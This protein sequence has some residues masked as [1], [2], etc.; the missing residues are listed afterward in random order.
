MIKILKKDKINNIADRW[1]RAYFLNGKWEYGEDKVDIYNKLLNINPL[2]ESVI[3][4]II[5]NKSWTNNV[6]NE[7]GEDVNVLIQIGQDP[8]YESA[9]ACIC[10]NCL[11][12]AVKLAASF[13]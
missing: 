10:L 9:T 1:K 8:D 6:C 7:C 13:T 3:N 5:G 4:E 2:T 12:K 11:N